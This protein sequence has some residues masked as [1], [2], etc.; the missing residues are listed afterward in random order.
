MKKITIVFAALAIAIGVKAS[1]PLP[2]SYPLEAPNSVTVDAAKVTYKVNAAFANKF[3][4]AQNVTWRTVEDFYFANFELNS[5][6]YSVAYSAQGDM[7]AL[8][9]IIPASQLPLAVVSSLE[10]R[11]AGYKIPNNVTEIVMQGSTNYYLTAEGATRLLQLKCSTD[12][13]VSVEKKIK[14]KIL[15]GSVS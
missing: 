2:N 6:N 15:V 13:T 10:E 9:R 4:K 14:K 7:L 1:N 8:S 5:N 3:K 11:F 12:G